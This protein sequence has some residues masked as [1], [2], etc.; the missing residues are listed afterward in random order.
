MS[1]SKLAADWH[2][3]VSFYTMFIFSAFLILDLA[4]GYESSHYFTIDSKQT[5]LRNGV[6]KFVMYSFPISLWRKNNLFRFDWW[7][8]EKSFFWNIETN[9]RLGTMR[10]VS[11]FQKIHY[12]IWDLSHRSLHWVQW[13]FVSLFHQHGL[14][15][16][17]TLSHCPQRI[18]SLYP[19]HF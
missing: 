5:S 2:M 13:D 11:L 7:L 10:H 19:L 15:V 14:T 18:V 8:H 9:A 4:L 6:E 12:I 17:S 16:P 3:L 1:F